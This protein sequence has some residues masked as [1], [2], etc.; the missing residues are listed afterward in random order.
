MHPG[1]WSIVNTAMGIHQK[2]AAGKSIGL[3]S[4]FHVTAGGED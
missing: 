1:L 2:H 4:T 3:K